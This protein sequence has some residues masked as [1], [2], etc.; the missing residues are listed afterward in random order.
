M[1]FWK[2]SRF[3]HGLPTDFGE[4]QARLFEKVTSPLRQGQCRSGHQRRSVL[5]ITADKQNIDLC[6]GQGWTSKKQHGAFKLDFWKTAR[7]GHGFPT[8]FWR[9]SSATVWEGYILHLTKSMPT[10]TSEKVKTSRKSHTVLSC[11]T[12]AE[13]FITPDFVGT[14]PLDSVRFRRLHP[15]DSTTIFDQADDYQEN[16]SLSVSEQVPHEKSRSSSRKSAAGTVLTVFGSSAGHSFGKPQR[17]C[18]SETSLL[19]QLAER[20]ELG[21]GSVSTTDESLMSGKRDRG[22]S[23]RQSMRDREIFIKFWRGRLSYQLKVRM[24][25]RKII[26]HWSWCGN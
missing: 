21:S 18:V 17:D 26:R 24:K 19:S 23:I 16:A 9:R 25:L 4:G 11:L 3:R 22:E 12:S 13:S 10:K 7:F 5:R 15:T 8:D 20:G 2:A 14:I 1:D 6:D